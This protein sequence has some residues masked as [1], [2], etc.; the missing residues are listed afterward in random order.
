MCQWSKMVSTRMTKTLGILGTQENEDVLP[1]MEAYIKGQWVPKVYVDGGAQ[2]C[3]MSENIMHRLGLEAQN[4]TEFKAKMAKN[5]SVKCVGVC[6]GVE[7]TICGVKIAT[8]L[9]VIPAKG[10]GY[11]IILEDLG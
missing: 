9:Y 4:K 8:N 3:V 2:V 10:E 6:K 11:P 5:V 1:V 7:I